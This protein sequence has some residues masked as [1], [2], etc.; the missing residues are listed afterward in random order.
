M[1]HIDFILCRSALLF[2]FVLMKYFRIQLIS[3]PRL[4]KTNQVI[5]AD[6]D[7]TNFVEFFMSRP[8][9]EPLRQ[10]WEVIVLCR[11]FFPPSLSLSA[12]LFPLLAF[13]NEQKAISRDEYSEL[14]PSN[15]RVSDD[16]N[17]SRAALLCLS[18][19]RLCFE[20]NGLRIGSGNK[21]SR[22]LCERRHG[23]SRAQ[24]RQMQ[25]P[26]H[27]VVQLTAEWRVK[28]RITN[29]NLI[30]RAFGGKSCKSCYGA[31]IQF[32]EN[33]ANSFWI[34]SLAE[35]GSFVSG[36]CKKN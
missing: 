10:R 21:F 3:S 32:K 12:F 9:T 18:S 13:K 19:N 16:A 5:L 22:E 29:E 33:K 15:S 2:T 25:L 28:M 17:Y 7:E 27:K 35:R 20:T 30:K 31:G 4:L 26:A 36:I 14:F 11:S 1:M 6:D 8:R 24:T 23:Q 34:A